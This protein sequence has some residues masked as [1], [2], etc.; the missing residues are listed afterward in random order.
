MTGKEPLSQEA[1]AKGTTGG[2]ASG[3]T[4]ANSGTGPAQGGP[5]GA[6]G[7][8]GQT[9]QTGKGGTRPKETKPGPPPPTHTP[10]PQML[11]LT[12]ELFQQTVAAAVTAALSATQSSTTQAALSSQAAAPVL[13]RKDKKLAEFWTTRPVMW[14]RLF[15]GHFPVTLSEDARFNALLNH[16]PSA[17]LP[18][19]DHILRDPGTTPFA[20]AKKSLIRHYE[21]SPRDRARTL[22]SL[23]SLGDRTPS[24]M[25]Y[26]MRSL[27]PGYPDNPLFEAIFID[28]LPAN[29]RDA[30]VKHEI[31]EDMAEAADKVLAE[32]PA[33][34][35]AITAVSQEPSLD[36][37]R[38]SQASP[39]STSSSGNKNKNSLCF[40]HRNYGRNAFKCASPRTC[41]MRDVVS[42]PDTAR[43][44]S[45]NANAGR[46]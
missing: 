34:S 5:T 43:P 31:L 8:I 6:A 21:I 7:G 37:A 23:T 14:F 32:A 45:G 12:Q 3:T 20:A 17:A 46:R 24:E 19:V 18:F 36:L 35:T 27:L 25:L 16:L 2:A 26:Y 40:V 28:L 10:P 30:A 11:Q 38:V 29:A 39:S 1:A 4:G 13:Q 42:R 15:D 9:G 33:A 22:R 41:S 44:A